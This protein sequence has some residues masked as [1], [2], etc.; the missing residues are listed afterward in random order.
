MKKAHL[1]LLTVFILTLTAC[2]SAANATGPGAAPQGGPSAGTLPAATQLIIGTIKL[3]GTDQAVTA[4]QA[5]ELLPLWQT[6]LVLS[7]SDTAADEEKDAL[8]TQI[9]ETMTA[10]QTQALTAMNLTREDMMSLMQQQTMAAGGA[11]SGNS[12]TGN[13]TGNSSRDFGPGGFQGPPDG[14]FN[15]GG[16]FG[17]GQN[18]SADQIA[19]A[20]AAR[21]AM[22]NTV[23]PLLINA[24]ID[25]LQKKAGA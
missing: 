16:P 14:G 1:I 21:Q 8:V 25:Y 7:N 4:E 15:G 6:M 19:T 24:V 3:D 20:Q 5:A 2:G 17:G 18:L 22:E 10:G 9:Q 13:S 11:Q 12:Q 23:P